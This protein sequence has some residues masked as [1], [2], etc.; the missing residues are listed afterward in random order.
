MIRREISLECGARQMM[1]AR[2]ALNAL[3]GVIGAEVVAGRN[4]IRMWQGD[5]PGE[6]AIGDALRGSGVTAYRIR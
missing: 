2:E 5:E 1:E 6:E 3:S 4:A